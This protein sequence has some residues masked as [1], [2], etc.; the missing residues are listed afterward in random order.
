[1]SGRCTTK[2]LEPWAPKTS[3]YRVILRDN[4]VVRASLTDHTSFQC[5]CR[6]MRC[7]RGVKRFLDSSKLTLGSR[8]EHGCSQHMTRAL[9][10]WSTACWHA[11]CGPKNSHQIETQFKTR[12]RH[13]TRAHAHACTRS[14]ARTKDVHIASRAD[15]LATLLRSTSASKLTCVRRRAASAISANFPS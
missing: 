9:I 5:S 15:F 8:E 4:A 7:S 6:R 1:M 12:E 13:H 3:A 14:W 2:P 10:S 11:G